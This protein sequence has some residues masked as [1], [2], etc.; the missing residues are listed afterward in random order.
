M[1]ARHPRAASILM[2]S[3][4]GATGERDSPGQEGVDV[5]GKSDLAPECAFL[6]LPLGVL[7]GVFGGRMVT[8]W[9]LLMVPVRLLC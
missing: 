4:E 3:Q 5:S 1:L 8:V 9:S 7:S 6:L 2:L